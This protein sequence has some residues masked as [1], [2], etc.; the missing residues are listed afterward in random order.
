[1]T[2][3]AA[4]IVTVHVPVPVHAPPQPVKV[5]P[6]EGVAVSVTAVPLLKAAEQVVPQLMPA[7]A[8]VTV[9]EP[10]RLTVSVNDC[11]AKVAVAER[12][13]FIVTVHAPVPV[14][15]PLQPVKVAPAAGVAV[16]V[17]AAPAA[18]DAEQVVPQLM[19]AGAL[20]TVPDP[21]PARLTLRAKDCRAKVAVAEL[22]AFIVTV[23]APV[24]VHAPLQPVKVAPAAGV[25]VRVTAVPP[26]KDAEQVVPQL[27]PAGALV[28]VPEPAP[29]RLTVSANDCRAK[30]AVTE[31]AAFIV[32]VH[33]PVP[34]HAP[35]QPVNVAPAA[36]V[37][38][39][40]TAVPLLKDA[41][42][43]VP[44]LMPAGALVTVP[45]PAPARLTV[46][47]KDWRA[48][49]AVTDVAAFIVT[50]QVPVPEQPPPVQPVN[51]APAEG[52][53]VSVTALPLLN[54]AEH[55]APQLMPAGALV[56]VPEPAPERLTVS[57][58][59]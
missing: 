29:A 6:A 11:S 33:A 38:V 14:H 5:A 19:P 12:A 42:Q 26:L 8:L 30:V 15:A 20:V 47:A 55:V 34:V 48:K 13:A 16:S 59:P 56:T 2:D 7:G 57:A 49:L 24:P 44:Q 41:E 25:A 36:G 43:V 22:A 31:L 17:T 52:V 27:I 21:A 39:S 46:S 23:H 32:T 50:V 28:T 51:V 1:V 3:V 37:A 9:P 18:N 35:L 40:V 45:G 54:V 53:A 10:A 58:K 4:L